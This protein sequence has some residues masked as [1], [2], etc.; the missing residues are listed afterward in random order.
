[1]F[2][3]WMV[4]QLGIQKEVSVVEPPVYGVAQKAILSSVYIDVWEGKVAI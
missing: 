2:I 1:M 4:V 3:C